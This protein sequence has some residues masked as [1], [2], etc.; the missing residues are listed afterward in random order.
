M[1][2]SE[3]ILSF[4]CKPQLSGHAT[5]A[6]PVWFWSADGTQILWANATGAAIF[7]ADNSA[8]LASIRFDP[9]QPTAAQIAR[10]A[11]TLPAGAPP[12]LE[13]LRGFGASLG[14]TLVC[15]CSRLVV[16]D[17]SG[18]LMVASEFA[19]PN[20]AL[21]ERVRRLLAGNADASAAFTPA[22][23][24]IY[25]SPAAASLLDTKTSLAAFGVRDLAAT[26]LETGRARGPGL[27]GEIT[28]ARLGEGTNSVLLVTF[29]ASAVT[30]EQSDS[31][32]VNSAAGAAAEP[33]RIDPP[34][35]KE[36]QQER[37][38]NDGPLSARLADLAAMA[39]HADKKRP[40]E[41]RYPLR[42][43]WQ[44][45]VDGRFSIG[46]DEFI[47][48][49]G[50]TIAA[51]LGKPW[52]EIAAAFGVDP[53]G[54]V[55]RAI[56]SRDTWSGVT[57]AWP[58]EGSDERLTVEMSGLPIYD[59]ERAYRGYRGFGVCRDVAR[60][61]ALVA[62][63]SPVPLN[64]DQPTRT[65]A[66]KHA[67]KAEVERPALSLVAQAANVVPF[68]TSQADSNTATLSPI[69]RNAFD[70][71][72][73]KLSERLSEKDDMASA[74]PQPA[75]PQGEPADRPFFVKGDDEEEESA[76]RPLLDLIPVGVLVYQHDRLIFANAAF[77][78]W[79]GCDTLSAFEEAGGLDSLLVEGASE[80]S[81]ERNQGQSLVIESP[82]SDKRQT[83]AQLFNVPWNGATAMALILAPEEYKL[84]PGRGE[85]EI[86]ELESILDTATDGVIVMD[87]DGKI[88]TANRS[89]S[90]LF[91]YH[92]LTGGSFNDLLA[93]DSRLIALDHLAR[94]AR[95]AAAS[96]RNE[97][98]VTGLAR[99][100]RLIP[101]FMTIGRIGDGRQKFCAVFRDLTQW[102]KVEDEL[103]AAKRQA[104]RESSAK[105][106]F[107]AKVSHEIRTP[108]NAI[109]GFSEIMM[110][111]R[112]GPV[113]NERYREYLK[114]IH[115]SGEHLISLINDLL[116]LSKIEAGK[117][118]L[119]FGNINLNDLTEQC[120]AIMQP[121][122]N[123][124]HIIIRTSLP[125]ALPQIVADARS[126]RQ[127]IL[128]LLSNSVK[129]TN[130]GGQV[131]V[132][133][134][135]SDDGDVALRVRDT[136]AGMSEKEIETALEPFRQLATSA[137][138]SAAGTGLGLPLT[139]ALAEANRASFAIKSAA[140]AGTLAEIVF[141]AS[142]IEA[143]E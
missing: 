141:P 124:E 133:T 45:D 28:I 54:D 78:H 33:A 82:A 139:K 57:I 119:S 100:G 67:A 114:D 49:A 89:A 16:S 115:G 3:S 140:N 66:P 61:S 121:Q 77:L 126:V 35:F 68:R 2:G 1:S 15:A 62:Q 138:L 80:F 13:R 107:L 131:I 135:L 122:A 18:L 96:M 109:I 73:R 104:E 129:F 31:Q 42:F 127:I 37:H 111:E 9:G 71:L 34:M 137:H 87:S 29:S 8:A 76:E 51:A 88:I 85:A 22:G 69:E 117:L 43:V 110:Q 46:S 92:E 38:A 72:A 50:P 83:K 103:L 14:R 102:K 142:R 6:H 24:L 97:G 81:S 17:C 23:E 58:V 59:R 30:L 5:S 4:L 125:Q 128:N 84:P 11:A 93:P 116:D 118:E 48:L 63:R 19:G 56:A 113:G 105:S 41:R 10:L 55:A 40:D 65:A 90:A 120:V 86:A 130:A 7:G 123:R 21:S 75:V 52:N 98:E 95:D 47:E 132:S 64:D 143:A 26:A 91:G 106:A 108:L 101:L 136:G 60:I 70:E 99:G 20:L 36:P 134:T 94:M 25:A 112:F 39:D 79:A 12:R 32:S 74:S 53:K 44:M 27:A